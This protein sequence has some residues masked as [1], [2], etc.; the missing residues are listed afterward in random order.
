MNEKIVRWAYTCIVKNK[1]MDKKLIGS[2]KDYLFWSFDD[3][4]NRDL[5]VA[6]VD[7]TWTDFVHIK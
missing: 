7:G 6:R 1:L 3:D 4:N 2:D 5:V